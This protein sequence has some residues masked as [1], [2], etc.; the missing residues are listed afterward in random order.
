LSDV[1]PVNKC[2]V[3]ASIGAVCWEIPPDDIEA[4]VSAADK[5]MYRVKGAGKNQVEIEFVHSN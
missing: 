2:N 4:M 5:V 3:S 1:V